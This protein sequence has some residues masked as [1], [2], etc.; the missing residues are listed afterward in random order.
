[1][2]D[3]SNL[4][5]T[6]LVGMVV[7]ALGLM[8]GINTRLIKKVSNKLNIIE[9]KLDEILHILH[10]EAEA[11]DDTI[12]TASSMSSGTDLDPE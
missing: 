4:Y 8:D 7:I 12:S 6:L 5:Y 10:E 1:M 9:E 2:D 3:V 11:D